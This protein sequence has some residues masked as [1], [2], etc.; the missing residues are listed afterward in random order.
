MTG[1]NIILNNR[2]LK[3]DFF[4]KFI[5]DNQ[6]YNNKIFKRN[7]LN[8]WVQKY[9]AYKSYDF[10]QNSSNGVKWFSLSTKENTVVKE[11][12]LEDIPF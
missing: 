3:S 9:A 5:N 7:T 10:D 8:R 6:D 1:Y 2:I 4:Q 11:I 12:E